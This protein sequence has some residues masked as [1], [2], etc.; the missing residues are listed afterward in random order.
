MKWIL[1]CLLFCLPNACNP[2]NKRSLSFHTAPTS[3]THPAPKPTTALIYKI[4]YLDT[5]KTIRLLDSIMPRKNRGSITIGADKRT[6][7]LFIQAPMNFIKK[8][9][10][11][12]RATDVPANE[13]VVNA[14]V[15]NIDR[16]Y[17]RDLGINLTHQQQQ[18]GNK[19]N[20]Q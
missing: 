9:K 3:K 20:T 15:I 14:K 17:I 19:T 1:L 16:N 10:K 8:A 12:L 18:Q 4:Q 11:W 5:Q 6:R 2:N 13:I 7:Q